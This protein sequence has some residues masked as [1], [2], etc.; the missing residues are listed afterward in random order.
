MQNTM[1]HLAPRASLKCAGRRARLFVGLALGV[2][3]ASAIG[4]GL[5]QQVLSVAIWSLVGIA[6]AAYALRMNA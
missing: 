5:M 4:D 3:V 1:Q 6:V 2:L